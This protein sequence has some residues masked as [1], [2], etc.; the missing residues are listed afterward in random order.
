MATKSLIT[1]ITYTAE[2]DSD[3]E[4]LTREELI[5]EALAEALLLGFTVVPAQTVVEGFDKDQ[6]ITIGVASD[7]AS[8][9]ELI[10]QD[11]DQCFRIADKS[12]MNF[13]K[14]LPR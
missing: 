10:K 13:E 5:D 2:L 9:L 8:A 14:G 7:I 6:E 1:W 11:P 12:V 3:E 4:P